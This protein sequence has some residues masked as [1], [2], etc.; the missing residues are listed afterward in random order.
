MLA[1]LTIG[2]AVTCILLSGCLATPT[3]LGEGASMVTGSGG[4][5]GSKGEAQHFTLPCPH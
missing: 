3:K 5:A 4:N 2:S 1:K